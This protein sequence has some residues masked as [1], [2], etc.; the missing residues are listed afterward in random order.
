TPVGLLLGL[1][2][3]LADLAR[4]DLAH[5]GLDLAQQQLLRLLGRE[6]GDPL[7][8]A[9]LPLARPLQLA[10]QHVEVLLAGLDLPV[11]ALERLGLAVGGLFLLLEPALQAVDFGAALL[12]LLLD[13]A[14]Q[15]QRLVFPLQDDLLPL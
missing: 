10:A 5:L 6:L 13:F 15:A 11:A 3:D 1:P 7:D 8:L 9:P 2:L 12:E 4:G 14:P